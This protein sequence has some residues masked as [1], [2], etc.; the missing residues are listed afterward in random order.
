MRVVGR[1]DVG[2]KLKKGEWGKQSKQSSGP[3]I[4]ELMALN[5]FSSTLSVN[6]V[7]LS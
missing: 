7:T 6:E 1:W 3:I 5:F 4:V 2:K